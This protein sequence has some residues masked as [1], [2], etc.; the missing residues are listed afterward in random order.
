[1]KLTNGASWRIFGLWTKMTSDDMVKYVWRTGDASPWS[2]KKR[3]GEI[4][5]FLTEKSLISRPAIL[6]IIMRVKNSNAPANFEMSLNHQDQGVWRS[7]RHPWIK[8]LKD[9]ILRPFPWILLLYFRKRTPKTLTDIKSSVWNWLKFF[10]YESIRPLYWSFHIM[11][12]KQIIVDYFVSIWWPINIFH[13]LKTQV[14]VYIQL[15]IIL[16]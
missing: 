16:A 3:I 12:K 14:I 2:N 5:W 7:G 13:C 1:M 4:D 10:A 8:K 6:L 15:E 11:Q 9:F